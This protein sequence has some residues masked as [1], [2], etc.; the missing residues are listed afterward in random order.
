MLFFFSPPVADSLWWWVKS[1]FWLLPSRSDPLCWF[2]QKQCCRD[3]ILCGHPPSKAAFLSCVRRAAAL[4][5]CYIA[6]LLGRICCDA[7][8]ANCM[9]TDEVQQIS[10]C[11]GMPLA[12]C[13]ALIAVSCS[14]GTTGPFLCLS[15]NKTRLPRVQQLESLYIWRS[16]CFH[17][18]SMNHAFFWNVPKYHLMH[19]SVVWGSLVKMY[20]FL[21]STFCLAC[22]DWGLVE[23]R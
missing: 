1:V 22:A 16:R 2:L 21:L 10:L 18:S 15:V 8:K 5:P 20:A 3:W 12:A 17:C 19:I 9:C 4:R 23:K 14:C 7:K 11:T 13:D 6:T